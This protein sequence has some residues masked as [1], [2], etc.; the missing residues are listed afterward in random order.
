[1]Q[2]GEAQVWEIN[3]LT[4]KGVERKGLRVSLELLITNSE[5]FSKANICNQFTSLHDGDIWNACQEVLDLMM[6]LL[7][8]IGQKTLLFLIGKNSGSNW[9][10][11]PFP[12]LGVNKGF[13]FNNSFLLY[14]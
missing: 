10:A 7:W 2:S 4:I 14:R 5:C 8:K 3:N 6:S 1:L 12:G 13:F 11:T 9:K